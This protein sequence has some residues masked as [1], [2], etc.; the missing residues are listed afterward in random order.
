IIDLLY[1]RFRLADQLQGYPTKE[2]RKAIYRKKQTE[3]GQMAAIFKAG[4]FLYLLQ[5][6]ENAAACFDFLLNRFPSREILNNLAASKLQQALVLYQSTEPPGF[7]YPIELDARSR[8][9][10]TH[11]AATTPNQVKKLGQLLSEARRYSEKSREID[12]G[13][14]PAYIN[15]ACVYSIQGNQA[16]A[17]GVINELEPAKISGNAN[18]V[19]AIAYFKDKEPDKARKD[20][21]L[22]RQKQAYQSNYNLTL[23]NKLQE[24]LMAS[25]TDWIQ[26]WF[27]QEETTLPH[28]KAKGSKPEQISGEAA[29]TSVPHPVNT[30]KISEKPY[31]L[32]QRNPDPDKLHFGVQ[33][34]CCRYLVRYTPKNY[35][36]KTNKG[37]K[38]GGPTAHLIQQYGTPSYTYPAT[39]G[40]YW[41]YRN[42]KIGFEMGQN[43]KVI[44]WFIYDT[45]L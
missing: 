27:S 30:V 23:F 28:S 43:G 25:L 37:I 11:R 22:A 4:Q 5:E 24:P 21:E 44:N 20:F 34:T 10:S 14:V 3:A 42:Q 17:I 31:L 40:E 16:A 36:G 6:F 2:E 12:P 38:Q 18:T 9:M 1:Q 7:I 26:N 41:I 8:L 13:Y 35:S 33:T 45:T 39:L 19:R 32:L 29:G 15:L